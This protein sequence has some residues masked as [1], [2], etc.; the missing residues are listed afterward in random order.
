MRMRTTAETVALFRKDLG[1]VGN[2]D[3]IANDVKPSWFSADQDKN[4]VDLSADRRGAR[5]KNWV[6][7]FSEPSRGKTKTESIFQ[8]TGSVQTKIESVL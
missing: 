4:R 5:Q 3:A 1:R 7:F 2:R 8:R 6:D